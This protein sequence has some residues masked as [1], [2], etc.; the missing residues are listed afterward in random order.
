MKSNRNY[1]LL[2][3][4]QFL[5]AFGDNAILMVILGQL[6]LLA[7]AGQLSENELRT[8]GSIYTGLLFIPYILLA[9]L[10]GYLND[11]YSKTLWLTGGNA[12][13][14]LGTLICALSIWLGYVWQAPGYFVVGI[15]SCLYG[16]AKYG[17][18]PEILPRENL[19]KANGMVELLT[20]VAILFGNIAGS[21][22]SDHWSVKMCYVAVTAIF[23]S[24]LAMNALMTK[25][26]SDSSI[27]LAKSLAEFKQHF[28]GIIAHRRLGKVLLGTAIFWLCGATM[29][30]NFQAWGLYVLHLSTNT[31]IAALGL[32]L[33][34]GIMTGSIAAGR[35]HKVGD[36]RRTQLYGFLL[37][38]LLLVLWTVEPIHAWQAWAVDLGGFKMIIPVILLLAITGFVAG[39]FLIPLNAALQA[40]SDPT[41]L[42]KTIAA[43]NLTDN[44]AMIAAAGIGLASVKLG[45]SAGQVF[46]VLAVVV[47]LAVALLRL[48][49]QANS[50]NDSPAKRHV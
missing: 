38:A 2:L 23:A 48:P 42:G 46:I 35:I 19:V 7:K 36:L 17:I 32:W 14:L 1:P 10:A 24:S 12:V 22:M 26:P 28:G 45:L 41:K 4:S 27:E 16:P 34:V 37:A 29:K 30:L 39:L 18:L 8:R 3:G 50:G 44:G 21:W 15:G 20:L 13:K 40:E 25:T 11:R 9:P 49:V 43:Q 5:S 6:T 33:A 47:A 31:E